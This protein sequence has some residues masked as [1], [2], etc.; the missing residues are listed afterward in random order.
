MRAFLQ[1]NS[2][3]Q[4]QGHENANTFRDI[5]IDPFGRHGRR[6]GTEPLQQQV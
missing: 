5:Q 2:P 3:Y 4:G 1:E 6:E